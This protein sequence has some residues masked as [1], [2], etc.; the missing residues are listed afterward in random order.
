M[1]P[2]KQVPKGRYRFARYGPTDH[3]EDPPAAGMC[4][5]VFVVVKRPG[6]KGVLLGLPKPDEKWLS[7]WLSA[8]K[9][10]SEK[11]LQEAYHQWRLP[12]TYL[13][14]GEHPE[15]AL[16]RIMEDQVGIGSYSLSKKGPRVF[17][18]TA[19][20]DWYP[21][22]SHWDLALVYDVRVR[23]AAK[24]LQVPKWWEQLEFV[25]KK[26][27]FLSKD[28]GWNEDLMRDLLDLEKTSSNS[29]SE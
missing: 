23:K 8:W 13:R 22:N 6:K 4:L 24:D 27:D 15:E 17:S 21:G 14:E 3:Y 16:R 28:Y 12:S 18:Y 9:T 20:S 1:A 19:P 5:S 2:A 26:K 29:E 11:E 7:E 10:Y 25:K